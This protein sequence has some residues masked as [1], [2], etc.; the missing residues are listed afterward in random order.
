MIQDSQMNR[1]YLSGLLPEKACQT[2]QNLKTILEE[3][4]VET[5]YL[6]NTNDIWCRDYMPVQVGKD[7]FQHI[8][9]H[10][11][12]LRGNRDLETYYWY[13]IKDL[14]ITVDTTINSIIVDGGNVVR[15]GNKVVM[16]AKVLEENPQYMPFDLLAKLEMAFNAEIILLPWDTNEIYGHADGI[17]RYVDD[18]TILM[19][20]YRQFDKDM[21]IRFRKCLK[22]H[23]KNVVE[24]NFKSKPL[25]QDSWAYINWLQTDNVLVVP[26]LNCDSD[27]EALEQIEAVMPSYKGRIVSCYCP[28]V[29]S[30]GGGLNCCTWTTME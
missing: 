1:V 20:N 16:T 27:Q 28:D 30:N 2:H 23:F 9:Y 24:L 6:D 12:Y 18:D 3:W 21:A 13:A 25:N 29:I 10:P 14:G 26:A 4:N 7:R 8:Y 15:C 19:T 11:D 5:H 17:C 22:P